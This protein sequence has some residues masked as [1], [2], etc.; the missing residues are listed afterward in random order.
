MLMSAGAKT[1]EEDCEGNTAF[2]VKCYGEVNKP[3][4]ISAIKLLLE[5]GAKI[6]IR[7]H[8]VRFKKIYIVS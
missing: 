3:S 8:R 5:S 6:T 7:N 4:E 1:N 2:H